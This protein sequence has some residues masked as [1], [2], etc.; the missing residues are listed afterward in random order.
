VIFTVICNK[1]KI[2]FVNNKL[3]SRDIIKNEAIKCSQY[4]VNHRWIG[5]MLTNWQTIFSSINKLKNYQKSENIKKSGY[6]KKE[7]IHVR[8]K[9]EKLNKLIGG[10]KEL[11]T[12]PNVIFVVDTKTH[13][14]AIK[15]AKKLGILVIGIVDTNSNPE[16]IDFVV[17][18]NDDSRTAINLYCKLICETVIAAQKFMNIRKV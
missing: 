4:Y 15:E 9:K 1:G 3:N 8:K 17:P 14:I 16:N 10:I 7:F 13:A 18:G 12:M 2:L 11:I 6:T 5:G